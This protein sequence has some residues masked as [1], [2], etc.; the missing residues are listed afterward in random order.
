[1]KTLARSKLFDGEA[2]TSHRTRINEARRAGR[3]ALA[4]AGEINR[5]RCVPGGWRSL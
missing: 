2:T 3:D 5:R 4:T 1:M